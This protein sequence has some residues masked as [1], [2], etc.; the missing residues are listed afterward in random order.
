M[1]L[2]LADNSLFTAIAT[3][4]KK[5]VPVRKVGEKPDDGDEPEMY[6]PPHVESGMQSLTKFYRVGMGPSSSHT[7]G[8][9]RA[10]ER[11]LKK[12]P[13]CHK[14]KVYCGKL[15]RER[16]RRIPCAC[17]CFSL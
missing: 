3:D 14:F 8:P 4:F 2:Y 5:R 13:D 1:S 12:H 7:M 10:C 16:V 9:R 15:V 11:F 17:T 6:P